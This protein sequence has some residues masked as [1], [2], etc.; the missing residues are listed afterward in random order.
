MSSCRLFHKPQ[1]VVACKLPFH[2]IN[3]FMLTIKTEINTHCKVATEFIVYNNLVLALS[4]C[5]LRLQWLLAI[6]H[7]KSA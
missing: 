3:Y 6:T 7:W 2:S 1:E 5:A 4:Q